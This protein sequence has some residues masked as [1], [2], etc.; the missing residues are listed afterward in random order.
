MREI[1][2]FI[3]SP[4]MSSGLI[5][6]M[7]DNFCDNLSST[8][9]LCDS[10]HISLALVSSIHPISFAHRRC[11]GCSYGDLCIAKSTHPPTPQTAVYIYCQKGDDGNHSAVCGRYS[12]P[13]HRPAYRPVEEKEHLCDDIS[14]AFNLCSYQRQVS[15]INHL[16]CLF[17]GEF[18]R[19]GL[20]EPFQHLRHFS[21]VVQ[22]QH[23]G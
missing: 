16:L 6:I 8:P 12:T 7:Y 3:N 17:L 9:L 1:P 22:F 15:L 10:P 5:S 13:L 4:M 18:C 19:V 2:L 11:H 20:L 21:F 23:L 14:E